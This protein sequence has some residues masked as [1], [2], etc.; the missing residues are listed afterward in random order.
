MHYLDKTALQASV[1]E[2]T[3]S[4]GESPVNR[5]R[6]VARVQSGGKAERALSLTGIES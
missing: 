1:V 5:V 3:A 2:T 6:V 4:A